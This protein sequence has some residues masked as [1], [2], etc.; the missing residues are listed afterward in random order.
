MSSLELRGCGVLLVSPEDVTGQP[1]LE[2][3][4]GLP[5]QPGLAGLVGLLQCFDLLALANAIER[6]ALG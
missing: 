6:V 2:E 3:L 4:Q 5:R 1:V